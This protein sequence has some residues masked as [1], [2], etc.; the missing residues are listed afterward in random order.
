MR[1]LMNHLHLLL[2]TASFHFNWSFYIKKF[3]S[4][5]K[6]IAQATSLGFSWDCLYNYSGENEMF[7]LFFNK[8]ILYAALPVIL[9]IVCFV[10][11]FAYRYIRRLDAFPFGRTICSLVICSFLV[12][13]NIVAYTFQDFR[14]VDIDGDMRVLDDMEIVCWSNA[15]TS[16]TYFVAIPSVVV[17][18]LGIPFVWFIYLFRSKSNIDL[19]DTREKWGFLFGGYKKEFYFWEIIIVYRKVLI[20][21]ISVYVTS[22]GVIA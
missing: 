13:P 3:Y 9:L 8:L 7:R 18:G 17:W 2:I 20:I 14:C 15:H 4:S 5:I 19:I 22:F 11:W 21:F 1:I 12:H 6:P 16:M 10:F